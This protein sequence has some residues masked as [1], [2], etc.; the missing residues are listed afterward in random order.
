M[1]ATTAQASDHQT[2]TVRPVSFVRVLRSEWVK[3]WSLRSTYWSIGVAIVSMVLIS[4]IMAAA[5]SAVSSDGAC[6]AEELGLDGTLVIGVGY[7]MS[8]L[9]FGVLRSE[10]R[11][12]GKERRSG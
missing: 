11:R 8:Q 6:A 9:V 5:A 10:E 2:V 12:V 4:L 3:F 1:G 7:S